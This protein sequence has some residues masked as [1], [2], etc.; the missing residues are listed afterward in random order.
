LAHNAIEAMTP[1]KSG[2]RMLAVRTRSDSGGA[3]LI[4][5]EDS[6]PGIDPRRLE[7]I[8]DPF[9]TTKL[10]GMGLGLAICS[11]IVDRHGGKLTALSDGESGARFQVWLPIQPA[12][13][14]SNG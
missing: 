7:R 2:R 12:G 11:T 14:W 4:E 9:V 13:G 1:V 5:V 10:H 3:I 6:G 8:F